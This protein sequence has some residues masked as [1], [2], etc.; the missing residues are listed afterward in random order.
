MRFAFLVAISHLRARRQEAGISVITAVS[1][2]GV[3]V[4]VTAL[5][6]VLAVM[7]GF[8]VDLRDKILGSNAHVVVL[9]QRG[10][11]HDYQEAT[12]ATADVDGVVAAA[13]FIYYQAMVRSEWGTSGVVLKGIDPEL[14]PT[15]TD[16][17]K[18]ITTGPEGPTT[19][20]DEQQDVLD[21]LSHPPRA[22]AQRLDDT[23][24]LPGLLMGQ[25]LATGLAVTVGDKVHVINPIGGGTGPMGAPVPRVKAFRVAGLF[26]SGMYEYDTTWIY[27]D[28][29]DAQA[30]LDLDDAVTGIEARV[31][32]LD[33]VEPISRAV[34][35]ALPY[36]F[37]V[38]HW[39]NLNRSL[40]AALK[41]EKIVMGLILGLIVAVASLNIVGTL[42]L[43]VVTRAREIS[44]LRA[45]GASKGTI[46]TIFM[47]Q[48]LIVGLVG[49]T[50]GTVLGLLGCKLLEQIQFP[51][52]T[53]VYY[54]DTLPVIIQYDSVVVVAIAAVLI[55]FLATL[56]P[57]SVAS[58]IDPVEGLRYE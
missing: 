54:L 57:A 8:E 49:T 1:I 25:E 39:K 58:S 12:K 52:D 53:D 45:M 22:L 13:P 26:N 40:F 15:V 42:I 23:E 47:L 27:M 16:V 35:E 56:Y 44:I 32:D 24:E 50:V 6:M 3:T 14:S 31:D 4:G 9:N 34:G 29:R 11:I 10:E 33:G 20:T 30:F 7:E 46:R 38:R 28:I 19:E 5:I 18:N 2:M 37:Y 41:L 21:H 36:P 43:I 17:T 48:G 55:C 51:L